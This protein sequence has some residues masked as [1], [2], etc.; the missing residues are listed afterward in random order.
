[1]PTNQEPIPESPDIGENPPPS[2]MEGQKPAELPMPPSEPLVTRLTSCC[3]RALPVD[4]SPTQRRHLG[5][6]R[7]WIDEYDTPRGQLD[8]ILKESPI[9]REATVT[10][11]ADLCSILTT[12]ASH[13]NDTLLNE[14]Q[15][16]LQDA[17]TMYS[18][19]S[20]LLPDN[21]SDS[22]GEEDEI[23]AIVDSLFNLSPLLVD[24]LENLSGNTQTGASSDN[25]T[26]AP[27][28]TQRFNS[29]GYVLLLVIFSF[30]LVSCLMH[31]FLMEVYA[32]RLL[33]VLGGFRRA[34]FG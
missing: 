21:N 18:G 12:P 26:A 32:R 23:E 19:I 14:R 24:I 10:L 2:T 28:V 3:I 27:K 22:G 20:Q 1:M 31:L 16:V 6:F 15:S 9:L 7:L 29:S 11:L 5:R 17:R 13:P 30:L 4:C 25:T 8:K 34:W 33:V